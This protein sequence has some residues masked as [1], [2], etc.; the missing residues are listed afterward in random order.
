MPAHT[1]IPLTKNKFCALVS[2]P[3][4]NFLISPPFNPIWFEAFGKSF[5]TNTAF[6][7]LK[8]T[9]PLC[10][11]Q[12]GLRSRKI[13]YK[14]SPTTPGSDWSASQGE[15]KVGNKTC[16]AI[17]PKTFKKNCTIRVFNSSDK[18]ILPIHITFQKQ[19]YYCQSP[20]SIIVCMQNLQKRSRNNRKGNY[21]H[22]F[23][24]SH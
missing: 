16:Q 2:S 10:A 9:A 23:P 21:F 8:L 20:L 14:I 3:S 24:R 7:K 5:N 11:L 13:P 4:I 17:L 1:H 6:A 19:V 12:G 18:L 15:G 22:S